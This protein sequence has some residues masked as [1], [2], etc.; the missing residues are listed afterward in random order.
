MRQAI[1]RLSDNMDGPRYPSEGKYNIPII[2]PE[3]W[4][5]C[6]L[7]PFNVATSYKKDRTQVGVHF[8]IDDYQFER[9][10][11]CLSR[12]SEML[13]TYKCCLS[14]DYSI[15]TDFPMA[16]QIY[17]HYR[18]CYVGAF[19]QDLGVK[20]YPTIGWSD[21][22]SYEW[23]FDGQPEGATVCVSGVGNQKRASASK[24]FRKGYD[25]M[26]ERLHP[27]TILFYGP[28]PDGL[29]GN[30]V[31]LKAYYELFPPKRKKGV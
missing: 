25:A 30:I 11:N 6:D 8:F 17:N 2:K 29:R 26:L 20:V 22:R 9:V 10:W 24:L 14:P 12:Y 1:S 4:E 13:S 18:K 15:Y 7:I 3:A 19:L 21:E 27:E 5:P 16:M 28:V 31:R 23:C